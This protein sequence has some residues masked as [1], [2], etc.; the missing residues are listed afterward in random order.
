MPRFQPPV[1]GPRRIEVSTRTSACLLTFL[2]CG[3]TSVV[4]LDAQSWHPRLP[5]FRSR[6]INA[7]SARGPRL[8]RHSSSGRTLPKHLSLRP[9]HPKVTSVVPLVIHLCAFALRF[10][11]AID[12][13]V[14]AVARVRRLRRAR[15]FMLTTSCPGVRAAKPL[16]KTYGPCVQSAI[17]ARATYFETFRG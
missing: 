9:R 17:L 12:S 5:K 13:H 7:D 11:F 15:Y 8:L 10:C 6:P 4:S 2:R 14:A 1:L 3:N 16:L